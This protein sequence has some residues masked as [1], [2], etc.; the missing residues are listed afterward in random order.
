MIRKKL[1]FPI[2]FLM[3][4]GVLF[5]CSD[6]TIS[7]EEYNDFMLSKKKGDSALLK[8]DQPDSAYFYYNEAKN[9]CSNKSGEEYMFALLQMAN[10]QQN[11]GDYYGAEETITEGLANYKGKTYQPYFYNILAIS[12]DKQKNFKS[13]L[14]YYKKAF[15]VFADSTTKA[16]AQNNI[17]L[18]YLES[19]QYS[20]AIQLL[21]PL[22]K[23]P[24][25]TNNHCEKARV[26]DNLGYAQFKLGQAEAYPNLLKSWQIRDSLQDDLGRV[27]S[28]I[29]L[30]EYFKDKDK[31]LA[32]QY[33]INALN[34]ARKLK[35][36]DDVLEALRWIIENSEPTV[37]KEY[38]DDF[39]RINDSLTLARSA[40]KNQFAKIKYDANTALKNLE[41]QK[42][43]KQLY[44]I[45][46]LSVIVLSVLLYFLILSANKNKLK[47]ISYAT[48]TRIS[49]KL[50]DEL[51]NDVY[52]AMTFAETQNLQLPEKKET[53]LD[54]LDK[55]YLR[56]R[57]ISKENSS[58]N[59]GDQFED[60]LKEMLSGY[61]SNEVNIIIKNTATIQWS[62][63]SVEK[64]VAVYRVLQELL[65]NMKKH[66][67]A[68][69]VVLGFESGTK[70]LQIQYSD[71]G[72]GIANTAITKKGLQNAENRILAVKGTV[73]F[74]HEIN[75][76]FR[77]TIQIPN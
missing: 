24:H 50:H 39:F 64:K 41:I 59:T 28:N 47:T 23:N 16:Y 48:E 17:G 14:Q 37:A 31:A 69:L 22:L 2:L 25:L 15:A 3:F 42:G 32:Q 66:S 44:F 55:I 71:N 73:T 6:T 75:K 45:L 49:K 30:S 12:Y 21:K 76:G 70:F 36:P 33:A 52:N 19:G 61:S 65:V 54:N 43:Q 35:S 74:D 77:V 67:G 7:I 8:K 56:T 4:L 20:K 58:I 40:A 5:S 11:T 46:F 63:L 1:G 62:K 68:S 10:I 18:I 57:N 29:H 34:I 51:A 26:L 38:S 27:P 53:L 9:K 13:A 72:K 60:D